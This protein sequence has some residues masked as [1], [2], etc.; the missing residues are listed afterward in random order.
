MMCG[1]SR[2]TDRER[3][4]Y[5]RHLSLPPI[6]EDGQERL[7]A[8]RVLI[9]GLGGLG[10][11]IALHLAAAGVGRLALVDPDVVTL[12][13]LQRQVIHGEATLGEAKVESARSRLHDLNDGVSVEAFREPF[14]VGSGRR[15]AAGC[16]LIV[17]GT[18]SFETRYAMNDV[19]LD[20]GIPY[21]YGAVFQLEGQMSLF[22][23]KD[24]PCYRC[25]FPEPPSSVPTAEEAGILGAVPG[26]IGAL[27]AIEAIK[28][29]LGI[30]PCLIGRL[31]VF[32]AQAM[33]FEE[34]AVAVNPACPSCSQA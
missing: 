23:T 22:C 24:G 21:V 29:I 31:L 28:W 5:A 18:D 3:E 25:L 27:Q 26:T 30:E 16:D 12:S 20:L 14:T 8:A 2:L 1:M 33:R 34:I 4:R 7:K 19:C 10:S 6:G 9:V 11:S 17:D 32:D 15:I 13:N